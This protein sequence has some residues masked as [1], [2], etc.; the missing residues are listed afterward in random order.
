MCSQRQ[1]EFRQFLLAKILMQEHLTAPLET[2]RDQY[3][4]EYASSSLGCDSREL[5]LLFRRRIHKLRRFTDR[6][7]SEWV[8]QKL[9]EELAQRHMEEMRLICADLFE[10]LELNRADLF[11]Q[12]QA[13]TR[14]FGEWIA[15][16][17]GF[18]V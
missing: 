16:T 12:P 10:R 17:A 4:P 1:K 2:E 13:D 15:E 3:Y 5:E 11:A 7:L 14:D 18:S 8:D 9:S 6:Q